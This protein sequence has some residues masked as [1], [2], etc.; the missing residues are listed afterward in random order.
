MQF[1]HLHRLLLRSS[2]AVSN[3]ADDQDQ[4]SNLVNTWAGGSSTTIA[5]VHP[6]LRYITLWTSV[7]SLQEKLHYWQRLYNKQWSM[8]GRA[9]PPTWD[10]FI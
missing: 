6:S 8:V 2:A 3:N 7:H 4:E 10:A 1:R 5:P 9:V